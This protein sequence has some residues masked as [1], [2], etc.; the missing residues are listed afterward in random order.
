MPKKNSDFDADMI[1]RADHFRVSI[2][3]GVGKYDIREFSNLPAAREG[4][5]KM[6]AEI[7]NGRRGMIYAVTPEGRAAFVPPSYQP[8]PIKEGETAMTT[9]T[10]LT[11]LEIARLTAVITG[12]GYKRAK[13]KDAAI[14]RFLK[15]AD[16]AGIS[17]PTANLDMSFDAAKADLE[18]QLKGAPSPDSEP[19]ETAP[20]TKSDKADQAPKDKPKK[21]L[22]KRA[23]ILA[24]AQ[25]GEMPTPPDFSAK[26]H[27][28]FRPKLAQVVEM[29]E[30]G[31]LEGL[32]A[33]EINPISSS[34]KAIAKYRDL[35]VIALE[36]Q[37]KAEK[38]A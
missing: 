9:E 34:P 20:K 37:A 33:F 23:A 36:A 14:R 11:A 13:S 38:A 2:F 17:Q 7:K 5:I 1:E 26:T 4:A 35:C 24:A 16:E 3:L 10:K 19:A 6:Q 22:G 12:G 29:A 32:K 30:A 8:Q 31:N 21:P 27:T 28:R 15:L 18:A 25:A